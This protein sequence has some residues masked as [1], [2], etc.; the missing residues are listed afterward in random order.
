MHGRERPHHKFSGRRSFLVAHE[1]ICYR[2]SIIDDKT[3]QESGLLLV[4][5]PAGWTSHDVVGYLRRFKV[6]K[7]GHCGT[8]DPGATGLL[9]IVLGRA[10]KLADKFSGQDKFYQGIMTLGTVTTTQDADGEVTATADWSQITADA[11]AETCA[12]F[13]GDQMQTPPMYS[14]VKIDGQRLYKLARKGKEIDR[15]PRPI[16]IHSFTV[17]VV[18]L[19]D[20]SISVGCSKGTYVRTLC[21][22]VGD[23]LGCGAYLKSLRRTGCGELTIAEATDME[24]IKTWDRDTLLR[25]HIPL[26]TALKYV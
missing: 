22:D 23:R 7:V 19:P 8:L 17:D 13:V 11:V 20:V 16:T 25:H 10:T 24:T 4:D 26:E 2:M 3:L 14:A 5:K 1:T 15:M 18:D 6:G 9:V 21:A 12:A